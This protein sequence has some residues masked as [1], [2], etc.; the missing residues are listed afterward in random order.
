MYLFRYSRERDGPSRPPSVR[1][2]DQLYH[3]ACFLY[4][5]S[6]MTLMHQCQFDLTEMVPEAILTE[7]SET[8]TEASVGS[9]L[10]SVPGA[11]PASSIEP[12]GMADSAYGADHTASDPLDLAVF[13]STCQA[14]CPALYQ[15]LQTFVLALG[16]FATVLVLPLVSLPCV[17]LWVMRRAGAAVALASLREQAREGGTD[18]GDE[19]E[20]YTAGEILDAM[21]DVMLVPYPELRPSDCI[22]PADDEG[23]GPSR[24]SGGGEGSCRGPAQEGAVGSWRRKG[25]RRGG[26]GGGQYRDSIQ[27]GLGRARVQPERRG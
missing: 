17:Y 2:F 16:L 26:R 1:I 12:L 20:I 13:V 22:P 5:Y 14:T 21:D 15:S 25:Y 8:E 24:A 9:E 11:V 3:M 7:A 10:G 27:E 19:G 6:G 4:V 23:G 18:D